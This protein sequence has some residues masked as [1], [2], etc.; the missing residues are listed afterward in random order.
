MPFCAT[1]ELLFSIS[2]YRK[3][4]AKHSTSEK[5][6]QWKQF[7]I[8]HN[9]SKTKE[10]IR[11]PRWAIL[12]LNEIN[13]KL[14]LTCVFMVL[15]HIWYWRTSC[16]LQ[17]FPVI[18]EDFLGDIL[19]LFPN[20]ISYYYRVSS[21]FF[22]F[23]L[24]IS[25]SD[26]H[27]RMSDAERSVVYRPYE[28]GPWQVSLIPTDHLFWW[29]WPSFSLDIVFSCQSFPSPAKFS[30]SRCDRVLQEVKTSANNISS[31]VPAMRIFS[32]ELSFF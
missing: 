22:I 27:L 2:Y 1:L 16:P 15:F 10:I 25:N 12:R 24:L 21:I 19:S 11:N 14:T 5:W 20:S 18:A 8:S 29:E 9:I 30:F 3:I 31:L 13:I 17:N 7:P 4:I 23:I 6:Q 28:G 32:A 26:L